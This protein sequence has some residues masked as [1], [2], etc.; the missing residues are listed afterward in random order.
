MLR[1]LARGLSNAEIA[2]HLF[3]RENTVKTHVA[4][5]LMKLGLRD[6]VQAV[7][8]AYESGV[9]RPGH[10]E[11]PV[12]AGV[13]R[14]GDFDRA[15]PEDRVRPTAMGS[16][17]DAGEDDG[18]D[19]A[20]ERWGDARLEGAE[21]V[22]GADEDHVDGGHPPADLIGRDERQDVWRK[23]HAD[24]V[25]APGPRGRAARARSSAT[26]RRRRWSRREA[27]DHSSV[28]PAPRSGPAW[29]KITAH[30]ARP[31]APSQ[32]ARPPAP[33]QDV[34]GEDRQQR[35]RAAEED[36]EEVERDG[37]EQ[38][39]G[40]GAV[41]ARAAEDAG[42]VGRRCRPLRRARRGAAATPTSADE[43][44]RRR[45]GVD[46]LG[47]EREQEAAERGPADHGRL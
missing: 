21:L 42:E 4:R 6:R 3:V 39:P 38:E 36:G 5:M 35:D 37:A 40:V 44:Q 11:E 28:R 47:V 46:E 18:R 1:L 17:G 9:V 20:D 12:R 26:A 43:R 34:L 41:E 15:D 29:H 25:G 16:V 23:T 45:D 19:R 13:G 27:D 32:E 2:A 33:R 22:R 31:K 8:L 14:R 10:G 30:S 24:H 7:V